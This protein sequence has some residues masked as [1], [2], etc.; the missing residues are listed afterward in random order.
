MFRV[1]SLNP[2][3]SQT[4]Q[5]PLT[6]LSETSHKPLTNISETSHKPLGDLSETSHKPLGGLSQTS[7]KPL[8]NLS[9]TSQKPLTNLSETSHKH[10]RN[11]SQTSRRTLRN[12]SQTSRRPFTN[13]SE[14]SHKPRGFRKGSNFQDVSERFPRGLR[15]VPRG[16]QEVSDRFPRGF[17]EV[18]LL[19]CPVYQPHVVHL[20]CQEFSNREN[21][22]GGLTE[23]FAGNF[24]KDIKS[25]TIGRRYAP[26]G[27]P[28][29][30]PTAY[31]ANRCLTI[32]VKISVRTT[33]P[34][35][36]YKL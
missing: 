22:P 14:T 12:L 34:L 20:L 9:E 31:P 15:E 30:F 7:Q 36:S 29:V 13:L 1:E 27:L 17:R 19:E 11:L 2:D 35:S 4:S 5:K 33:P 8:T 6:N 18:W 32:K 25:Q 10:L 28:K 21:T 3:L 16:F 23:R 26:S 24:A